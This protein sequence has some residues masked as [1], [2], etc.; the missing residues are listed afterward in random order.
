MSG[1]FLVTKQLALALHPIL[2][3]HVGGGVSQKRCYTGPAPTPLILASQ[4]AVRDFLELLGLS[5]EQNT[6]SIQ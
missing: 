6:N 1:S 4:Q 2:P 3:I 5:A